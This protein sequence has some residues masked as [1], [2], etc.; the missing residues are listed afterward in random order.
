MI[1]VID[2]SSLISLVRYYLPFD[3]Q[4]ILYDVIKEKIESKQ[5]IVLDKVFD[6][7]RYTS[8]G[9]VVKRLEYLDDKK[10][11]TKTT[12]LLP[13]QKYFNQLENQFING[14]VK[15][16]LSPTEFENRKNAFLESADSNLLLFC[17]TNK[18]DYTLVTEETPA[19]NDG[20]SFKKL[21]ALCQILGINIISLPDL[22]G[23]FEEI[24]FEFK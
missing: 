7:C 17:Q 12:S 6:E 23:G 2:T 5:I 16:L 14:S 3:R 4:N 24:N 19:S 11:Q 22:L 21:P 13:T 20:K 15:N 9:I 8:Q 10:N 1:A 18:V